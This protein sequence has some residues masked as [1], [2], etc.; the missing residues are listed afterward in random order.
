MSLTIIY[1]PTAT[2]STTESTVTVATDSF[3]KYN[4]NDNLESD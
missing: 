2:P 4:W 1:Q 3:G